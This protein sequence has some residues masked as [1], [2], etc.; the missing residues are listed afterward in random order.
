MRKYKQI[1][2]LFVQT[3]LPFNVFSD[4]AKRNSLLVVQYC[5]DVA[6]VVATAQLS[7]LVKFIF[8]II[9]LLHN[10]KS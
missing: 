7:H 8:F 5:H 2:A 4:K 3:E 9:C 6:T 10:K 1:F